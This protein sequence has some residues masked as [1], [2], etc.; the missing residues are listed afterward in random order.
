MDLWPCCLWVV[1]IGWDDVRRCIQVHA[2]GEVQGW[3]LTCLLPSPRG[4]A[5]RLQDTMSPS[6]PAQP[7]P[8][9]SVPGFCTT[10]IHGCLGG[11]CYLCGCVRQREGRRGE[12]REERATQK[13][14]HR[15]IKR[16]T[17]RE[18]SKQRKGKPL[19]PG[20]ELRGGMP[21]LLPARGK[22]FNFSGTRFSHL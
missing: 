19:P 9:H 13:E 21:H 1:P 2:Q 15:D 16:G 14:T 22:C 7:D 10:V 17:C 8:S 18:G 6:S 11:S 20:L 3:G 5:L 12:G 4:P